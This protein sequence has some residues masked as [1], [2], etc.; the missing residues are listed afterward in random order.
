MLFA[1]EALSDIF[2]SKSGS[3][4]R[5][6]DRWNRA[7]HCPETRCGQRK[8]WKMNGEY[9]KKWEKMAGSCRKRLTILGRHISDCARD[10]PPR[11]LQLAGQLQRRSNRFR[12]LLRG[13]LFACGGSALLAASSGVLLARRGASLALLGSAVDCLRDTCFC[14]CFCF[15]FCLS[16]WARGEC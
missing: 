5:Q 1:N 14:F 15:C 2:P 9:G 8:W 4:N 7:H 6:R 13:R 3:Q 11:L 12:L 10:E 16:W